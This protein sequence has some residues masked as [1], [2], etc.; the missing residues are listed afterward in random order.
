MLEKLKT[1]V[2]LMAL[3]SQR[4]GLCKQG[5]GNFSQRDPETGLV[6]ITPTSKDRELLVD[7]DMVV[8][9]LD[10]NVVENL[11]GLKPTSEALVHLM[12]YKQRPDINAVAHT[13]SLYATTFAILNKPIPTI[14]YEIAKLGLTDGFLPVAPYGRPGTPELADTVIDACKR[15]N[16]FLMEKHGLVAISPNDIK[17]AYVTAAYGEEIAHLYYNSLNVL[18]GAEPTAL[19]MSELLSWGYPKEIKFPNAK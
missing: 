2:R 10:A 9:D 12:V 3:Q 15:A 11:T 1:D 14:V 5:A 16:C 8:M 19:P 4:D 17:D 18:Q 7:E 13:H 6:V